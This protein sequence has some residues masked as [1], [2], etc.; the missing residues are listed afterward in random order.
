MLRLQCWKERIRGE[1]VSQNVGSRISCWT[2]LARGSSWDPPPT[3]PSELH[4]ASFLPSNCKGT[5]RLSI[6]RLEFLSELQW[7][8][9]M[10]LLF[11]AK[12]CFV[13]LGMWHHPPFHLVN[14]ANRSLILQI[15]TDKWNMKRLWLV[16]SGYVDLPCSKNRPGC[17]NSTITQF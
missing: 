17:Q 15:T 8:P 12:T 16:L 14:I 11:I 1:K 13:K 5:S 4:T 9:G 7:I 3:H 2:R 6:S 10:T